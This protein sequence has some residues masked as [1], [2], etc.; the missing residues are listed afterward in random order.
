MLK[1]FSLIILTS[2]P[3]IGFAKIDIVNSPIGESRIKFKNND[4][5]VDVTP[6]KADA[7]DIITKL[8]RYSFEWVRVNEKLLVPR[9]R[10]KIKIKKPTEKLFLSYKDKIINFQGTQKSADT[11]L[12]V[13][14]YE[15]NS[16]DIYYNGEKYAVL[17]VLPQPAKTSKLLIDYT[18]SRNEIKVSGLS[19][20]H[21]S[22]GCSTRRIG[23][24]GKEKPMLEVMWVSPELKVLNNEEVPIHAVF[25]NKK[26]VQ[27]EVQNIISGE[28]KTISISARIP[29]RLH[30]MFTGIGFGPYAFNTEITDT[31]GSDK[32]SKS[33]PMAPA[34]FFYLN[35]K[36]SET[37]S[38]RGFDAAVFKESTFN[39]AGVYVGN[40]F[41]FSFDNKLYFTTLIGMQYLYFKY[42]ED[43]PEVSEAIFPQGIELMYRHAFDIPN[44]IIS[45]GIFLST[46]DSIEYENAWI[47][48]GK[49]YFWELNLISWGRDEFEV[50][51]WGLSVGFPFKGFL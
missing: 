31:E 4:W 2:I 47:R 16:I 45:G 51:T 3:I 1:L 22:I 48:W 23:R 38:V 12:F 37:T 18:C 42:D 33:E 30:R 24:F 29:K 13:S 5:K 34:L 32:L 36:I 15:K 25:L 11:E 27:I 49:S 46:T 41:G 35:Y 43:S 39:N 7:K 19:N 40:D 17:K 9:A 44:Y 20:E 50:K 28:K 10:V 8:D 21:F 26:P 14:L 6:M